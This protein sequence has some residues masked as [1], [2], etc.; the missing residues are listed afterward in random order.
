MN[1]ATSSQHLLLWSI[2]A[3][4]AVAAILITFLP[5][6]KGKTAAGIA[7]GGID[8]GESMGNPQGR[9]WFTAFHRELVSKRGCA[10]AGRAWATCRGS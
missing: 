4:P 1:T 7:V 2:P 9:A 10:R 3:L 5:A 6:G 8:I